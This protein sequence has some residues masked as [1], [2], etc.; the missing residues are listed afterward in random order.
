MLQSFKSISANNGVITY[1][2][3]DGTQ[4]IYVI[5]TVNQA[6]VNLDGNWNVAFAND[7]SFEKGATLSGQVMLK[8]NT[9]IVLTK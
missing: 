3:S 5:H 6:N 4:T 9:S 8:G 2:I 1:E 7:A